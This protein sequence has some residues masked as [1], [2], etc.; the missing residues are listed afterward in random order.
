MSKMSLDDKENI[1][2][3]SYIQD[4]SMQESHLKDKRKRSIKKFGHPHEKGVFETNQLCEDKLIN[5]MDPEE[6]EWI[7]P[8]IA[9]EEEEEQM[10]DPP[11]SGEIDV[12]VKAK[13]QL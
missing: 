5:V 4:S 11:E 13:F 3:S 8:S 12:I 10:P 7:K 9:Q 1:L 6:D 2:Q